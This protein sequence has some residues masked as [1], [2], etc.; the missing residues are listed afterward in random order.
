M[1]KRT[2]Q[3]TCLVT[4][5]LVAEVEAGSPEQAAAVAGALGL[6]AVH[7]GAYDVDLGDGDWHTGGELDGE[8]HDIT[9]ERVVS[10]QGA[11]D[12]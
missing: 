11:D 1:P 5:S 4:I 9:V 7:E 6:P 8:P 3:V 12:A 2:Y 10:S